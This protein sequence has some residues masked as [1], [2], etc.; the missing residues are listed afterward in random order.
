MLK[1]FDVG[2]MKSA[3]MFEANLPIIFLKCKMG[4]WETVTVT[5]KDTPFT[6]EYI[7]KMRTTAKFTF[8]SSNV[9]V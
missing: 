8:F 5:V 9:D 2:F 3:I 1:Y 4:G 7:T 6:I